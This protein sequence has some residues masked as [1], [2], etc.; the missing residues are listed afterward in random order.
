MRR[1]ERGVREA[2]GAALVRGA[3]FV[4]A[5][6]GG[7]GRRWALGEAQLQVKGGRRG[8]EDFVGE[9]TQV[10]AVC[11]SGTKKLCAEWAQTEGYTGFAA[12]S[13]WVEGEPGLVVPVARVSAGRRGS[14]G[15]AVAS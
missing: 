8:S 1:D 14:S 6:C 10:C 12:G 4:D 13:T 5:A 11:P 7:K 2:L 9:M 3:A 15:E